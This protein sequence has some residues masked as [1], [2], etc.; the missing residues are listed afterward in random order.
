MAKVGMVPSIEKT[1]STR[2]MRDAFARQGV[3]A[4]EFDCSEIFK[5]EG[6]VRSEEA[7]MNFEHNLR[8][9]GVDV[10]YL[11][12]STHV[13][14]LAETIEHEGLKAVPSSAAL[15]L[16]G[17]KVKMLKAL[18]GAGIPIPKTAFAD[19]S[20]ADWQAVVGNAL[21]KTYVVKDEKTVNGETVGLKSTPAVQPPFEYLPKFFGK[22]IVQEKLDVLDDF[23]TYI[24]GDEL[25]TYKRIRKEGEWKANYQFLDLQYP[26]TTPKDV[27]EIVTKIRDT[28]NLEYCGVDLCRARDGKVYVFELNSIA[29]IPKGNVADCVVSWLAQLPGGVSDE[30]ETE[31]CDCDDGNC[32]EGGQ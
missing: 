22:P 2:R 11:R 27:R 7:R 16:T 13:I 25:I 17:N 4:I 6:E 1:E 10:V 5:N 28:F 20:P 26:V 32:G 24:I 19:D 18:K 3:P 21:P 8:R 9:T 14:S 15:K 23:R 12:Q 29:A 31:E 30:S